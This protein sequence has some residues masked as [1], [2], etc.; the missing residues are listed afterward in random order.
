MA[1]ILEVFQTFSIRVLL[2]VYQKKKRTDV[3]SNWRPISLLNVDNKIASSAIANRLKNVLAN[4]ISN[5]QKGFYK[6]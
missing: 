4:I 6:R 5:T 1:M 3:M 2:L